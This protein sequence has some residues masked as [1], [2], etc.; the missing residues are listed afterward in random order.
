VHESFDPI[1]VLYRT[2][3]LIRRSWQRYS[4]VLNS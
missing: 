3:A 2:I 4:A 1:E